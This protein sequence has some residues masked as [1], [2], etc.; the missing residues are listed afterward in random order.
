MSGH[1]KGPWIYDAHVGYLRDADGH[2][3]ATVSPRNRHA[4][5]PL[6]WAAPKLLEA[7]KAVSNAYGCFAGCTGALPGAPADGSGH[8]IGCSIARSALAKAKGSK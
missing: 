1:S 2:G 3:I 7:L 8:H 5:G 6:L 4:N